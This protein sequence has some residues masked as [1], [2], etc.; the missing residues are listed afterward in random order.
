MYEGS[1]RDSAELWEFGVRLHPGHV[2]RLATRA[3]EEIG[4]LLPSMAAADSFAWAQRIYWDTLPMSSHGPIASHKQLLPIALLGPIAY[5]GTRYQCPR[6][7]P[8]LPST[9]A[10]D[11]FA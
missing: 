4:Q 10:A 6:M 5:A 3:V 1:A 8:W 9:A 11:S 2:A 7:G